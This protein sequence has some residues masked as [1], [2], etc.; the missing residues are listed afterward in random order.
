MGLEEL[1]P[2]Q[3]VH[4]NALALFAAEGA[5]RELLLRAQDFSQQR[6]HLRAHPQWLSGDE[7]AWVAA[8]AQQRRTNALGCAGLFLLCAAGSVSAAHF[9]AAS[10]APPLHRAAACLFASY[11]LATRRFLSERRRSAERMGE[12]FFAV[13][14]RRALS[15]Q[16]PDQLQQ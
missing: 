14:A 4:L 9:I 10:A 12:L 6:E 8:A 3:R 7:H 16:Q 1:S 11:L 2:A 5:E 13:R 15:P